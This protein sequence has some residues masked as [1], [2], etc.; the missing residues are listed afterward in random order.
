[1]D[2]EKFWVV[3]QPESGN[4]RYRHATYRAAADEAERL[5]ESAP[6]HEFFVLEAVS[7][8]KKVSVLTV[9]LGEDV[10]PF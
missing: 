2:N 10:L 3:W 5:A 8:S 7:R 6:Q 1:M 9:P 4:P